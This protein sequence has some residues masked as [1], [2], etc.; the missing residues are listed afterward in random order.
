MLGYIQRGG[1]PSGRDR[2]SAAMMGVQAVDVLREED[3]TSKVI[4]S[5]NGRF[6]AI[7]MEEALTMER[8]LDEEMYSACYRINTSFHQNKR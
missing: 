6:I 8:T 2:V 5:R 3:E 7:D 1:A 4:V